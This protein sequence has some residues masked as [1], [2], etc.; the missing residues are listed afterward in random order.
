M[1]SIGYIFSLKDYQNVRKELTIEQSIEE[2]DKNNDE[3]MFKI[4]A[5]PDFAPNEI[6]KKELVQLKEWY[7]VSYAQHEQK[8][9]RLHS[10]GKLTDEGANPY[11]ELIKLYNEAEIKRARIQELERLISDSSN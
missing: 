9:R 11:D 10:L 6:L 8:Y 5:N 2:I 3:R 4:I 7:D 1:Y